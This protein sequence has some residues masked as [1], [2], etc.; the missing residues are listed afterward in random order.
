MKFQFRA[1]Y[2]SLMNNDA[3]CKEDSTGMY[4][5]LHKLAS[6]GDVRSEYVAAEFMAVLK[7][8]K[9]NKEKR[10]REGS[11]SDCHSVTDV[12]MVNTTFTLSTDQQA[13]DKGEEILLSRDG[14]QR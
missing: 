3:V 6:S 11:Q 1:I 13:D 10:L 7:K 4:S 5:D 2:K 14:T 9:R 8:M 12:G